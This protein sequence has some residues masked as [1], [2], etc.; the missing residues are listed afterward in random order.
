MNNTKSSAQ[1]RDLLVRRELI[2]LADDIRAKAKRARR[3][4]R[5]FALEMEAR[6]IEQLLGFE[7]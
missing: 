1:V 6:E 2:A 5:K 7:V 4:D 3:L